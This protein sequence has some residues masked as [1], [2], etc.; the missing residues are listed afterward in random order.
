MRQIEQ[1]HRVDNLV[2]VDNHVDDPKV[3]FQTV[4]DKN[5][6][7][8]GQKAKLL[9]CLFQR[10]Q[11]F[12]ADV[13]VE[14]AGLDA[15]KFGEVVDNLLLRGN[16]VVHEGHALIVAFPGEQNDKRVKIGCKFL[17]GVPTLTPLCT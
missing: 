13:L 14:I 4:T 7:T 9:I 5:H 15:G 1:I 11:P 2:V 16:V 10:G 6:T 8:I 12:R 3:I 17:S